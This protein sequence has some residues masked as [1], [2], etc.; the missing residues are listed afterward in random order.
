MP[1]GEEASPSASFQAHRAIFLYKEYAVC[2]Y[3]LFPTETF[4]NILKYHGFSTIILPTVG[5]FSFFFNT[6]TSICC[7]KHVSHFC[8]L[9]YRLLR[10]S[11]RISYCSKWS[12]CIKELHNHH[13]RFPAKSSGATNNIFIVNSSPMLCYWCDLH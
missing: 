4:Q 1:S 7:L 8:L 12:F 11:D 5:L 10:I 13:C 6:L 9:L 2:T 3:T